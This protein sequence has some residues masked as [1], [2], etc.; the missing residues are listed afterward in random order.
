MF[1]NQRGSSGLGG[2][3]AVA[4][5]IAMYLGSAGVMFKAYREGGASNHVNAPDC[6]LVCRPA[7]E[8]VV[9]G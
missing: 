8:P 6:Q 5:L 9:K 2:I 1:A 4:L 3:V 7:A